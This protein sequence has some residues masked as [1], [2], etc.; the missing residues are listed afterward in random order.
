M[1]EL[2]VA[3][4]V[5]I[6]D[7]GLIISIV[8]I[9]LLIILSAFF[10]GSE[11]ALTAAS[12]AR[13]RKL[14][15][16]GND[17]A[18]QVLALRV[19]KDKMLGGLLLGNNLVN[20]LSPALATAILMA[21]FGEAGVFY[22]AIIMTVI[23]L[24]F[25]E[26]LPKTYALHHADSMSMR[27]VP[28]MKWVVMIFAPISE[29]V[30]LI[31]RQ[32]LKI[33]GV[34]ISKVSAGS[35]LE[36]LRGAI[37]M[38]EG[39]DNDTAIE[40]AMLRSVLDLAE[41]DVY[42]IM[43]HRS[44]V[45]MIDASKPMD[46]IVDAV[47]ESQHTRLPIYQDSTDNIIGIVHAKLLLR[48]LRAVDGDASALSIDAIT[49]D[50]WF[51]PETTSLQDQLQS[52]REKRE[53][54]ALVVDEYGSV[55]GIVTLEDILEEIVGEIEDEYDVAVQGVRKTADGKYLVDGSVTIRDLNREFDWGLPDEE[56]STIAG[57]ILHESRSI[58]KVG[59]SFVFYRLRFDIVRRKKNQITQVSI[60]PPPEDSM[61]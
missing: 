35:H 3:H 5:L 19:N 49:N 33:F 20:N 57:L 12:T 15:K 53:H 18:K 42:E 59:Q 38:H 32:T 25:A 55:M 8:G 2:R 48:E 50:P 23:V 56:Y 27:I 26:V 46:Q 9:V 37:E 60:T 29:A 41:V 31:V 13:L 17:R 24:I 44:S 34:D 16:D 61:Q 52:F 4:I 7:I 47:L 43:T 40:R 39:P 28:A 36:L 30:T 45:K 1:P 54:F 58:P 21:A 51:I 22:A 11:T 6:M 14:A 10:S